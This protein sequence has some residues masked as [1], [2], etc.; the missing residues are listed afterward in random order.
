M[1][2]EGQD[3]RAVDTQSPGDRHGVRP[4]RAGMS[5]DGPFCGRE[6]GCPPRASG[7]EPFALTDL[8]MV[9]TSAPRERG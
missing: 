3:S 6:D 8:T 1:P 9:P 5:P 7:D 2:P 4:A